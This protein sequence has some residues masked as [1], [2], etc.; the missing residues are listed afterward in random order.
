MRPDDG[1]DYIGDFQAGAG[2]DTLDLSPYTDIMSRADLNSLVTADGNDVT[3]T[4]SPTSSVRLA[5]VD[6]AT[7]LNG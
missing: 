6:H 5:N 7:F 2:G 4:F 1:W 3:I